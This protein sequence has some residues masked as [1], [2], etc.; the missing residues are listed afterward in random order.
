MSLVSQIQLPL[1]VVFI[2]IQHLN[3]S[4]ETT[5]AIEFESSKFHSIVSF[6][7]HYYQK[8]CATLAKQSNKHKSGNL[9]LALVLLLKCRPRF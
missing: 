6:F 9:L 2:I 5:L 1:R 4:D 7:Y 3:H 8:I